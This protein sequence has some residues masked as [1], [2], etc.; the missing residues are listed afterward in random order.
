VCPSTIAQRQYRG[1]PPVLAA[2]QH[3]VVTLAQLLGAGLDH[4]AIAR[5]VAGGA[6]HRI[7]RG[8]YAVGHPGLSWEG[9]CLAA[10]LACGVGSALSHLAAAKLLQVSRFAAPLIAVVTAS[11]RRPDRVEVHR[12]TLHARDVTSERNIPVTCVARTLV[13]LT[14]VLTAHQLANVIH[15]AAFRGR[16]IESATRDAMARANGRRNLHVLEQA[17]ALH[18]GGSAGT[19]SGLEDAFLARLPKWAA[20]PRVNTSLLDMEVDFHWPRERL[21]VEVD[22]SGHGRPR[23]QREDEARQRKLEEAG[24]A[25]LRVTDPG[26]EMAHV[27]LSLTRRQ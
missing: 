4:R 6:L 26:S 1:E 7:H 24:Y 27:E 25:V 23:T 13:D 3:G 14:D 17:I 19:K 18:R 8:V 2:R 9:Q 5:R 15:E 22:G 11:K 21:V 20:P 12:G 16:F 10:V